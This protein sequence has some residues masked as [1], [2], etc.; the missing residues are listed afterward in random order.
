[1][2]TQFA[3]DASGPDSSPGRGSLELDSVYHPFGVGEM[4]IAT[5]KQWVTAVVDCG[6][7]I[8]RLGVVLPLRV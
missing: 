3:S 2:V 8:L 4:C 7:S 6:C 1:V 5:S